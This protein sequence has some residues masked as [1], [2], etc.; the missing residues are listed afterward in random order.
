M[1][2]MTRQATL[3]AAHRWPSF[4][5]PRARGPTLVEADVRSKK[6]AALAFYMTRTQLN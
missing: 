2:S 3:A 6:L 4:T 1:N 5:H